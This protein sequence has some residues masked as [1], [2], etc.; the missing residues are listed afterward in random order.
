[1]DVL[2]RFLDKHHVS[3]RSTTLIADR[4]NGRIIAFPNGQ[5]G[6]RVENKKLTVATLTD[7]DDP[8]VREAYH[9]HADSDTDNFVFRSPANGD[10]LI[11][12]F[13]NFP[14][15]FGQPWQVITLTPI[16]DFVGTLKA[17]NRL[18]M[19]V[20]IILIAIELFFIYIA[21]SRLSR[22][23]ENVSRQLQAIESLQFDVPASRPSN[24]REIAGLEHAAALL[25]NSL[26][27]FSSFVP[28][29]I[30]RQLIKSGI[31][32]TL[33]VEPRYLIPPP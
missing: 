10:D 23:V 16:D 5:K 18:I 22:P 13:A 30:V 9:R 2:S 12:A 21:S 3:A 26:K 14:D 20:I 33:G 6:V 31:P 28:L 19:V 11:A 27:S 7:I 8:D 1:M 15:G 4:S 24:I 17:T 29:D 32:L 25:R